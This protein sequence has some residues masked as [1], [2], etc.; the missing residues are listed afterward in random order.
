MTQTPVPS[1]T[2][3]VTPPAGSP[4]SWFNSPFRCI[5]FAMRDAGYIG[6][7][8]EPTSDDYAE[9]MPRLNDV[10][11]FLQARPGLKL[12]LQEDLAFSPVAPTSPTQGT[13]LYSFG[14][15]GTVVMPR[16]PRIIEAYYAD[17]NNIRR[18]LVVLSRNEWD[19]LSTLNTQGEISSYFIDK[20]QL[21][22]NFYTW[23]TPD[24]VAA[25][26][27]V[28]ALCQIQ[29]N[30]MISL[31][32]TMNFP[33]E[34]F[35]ALHWTLGYDISIGQPQSV[36]K[37]CQMNSEKY[38]QILEDWDVEDAPTQFQPDPRAQYVANRFN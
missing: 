18:P 1:P 25:T 24:A 32:D 37:Q 4:S 21:L 9:Y 16:P 11:N 13:N 23:L 3:P 10:F 26:G 17:S 8:D 29:V 14:P 34:W 5:K 33:Q 12:W 22:T 15:T 27:M 20:Q 7:D 38:L 2:N 31:T 30:N 6:R 28:H 35:G 19:Y 36:I